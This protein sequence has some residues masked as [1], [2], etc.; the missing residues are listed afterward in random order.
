MF[1]SNFE[2]K[3]EKVLTF[4]IVQERLPLICAAPHSFKIQ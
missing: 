3:N 1:H 2:S 4:N